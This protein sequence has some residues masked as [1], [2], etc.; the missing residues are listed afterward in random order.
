MT[1]FQKFQTVY[2]IANVKDRFTNIPILGITVLDKKYYY[3][4]QGQYDN[5]KKPYF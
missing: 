3:A 2:L 1:V 4:H 5:S